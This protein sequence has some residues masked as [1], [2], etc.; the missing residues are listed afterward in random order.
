MNYVRSDS[1]SLVPG[2]AVS[3]LYPGLGILGANVPA[4]GLHGPSPLLNDLV[5]LPADLAV[6]LRLVVTV[7]PV[8]LSYFWMDEDGSIVAMG[9]PG[10]Y[11][12]TVRL[13]ADGVDRGTTTITLN[14][15]SVVTA[16][17]NEA[18]A[19]ADLLGPGRV[20]VGQLLELL[21]T[22]DESAG[23]GPLVLAARRLLRNNL[24]ALRRP[25]N[26]A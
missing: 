26:Q 9:A 1:A 6:Q 19:L 18:A 22:T 7:R 23:A 24:S 10:S 8:G 2:R 17:V 25:P 3:S 12:F 14:F 20:R 11:P 4:T 13:Y 21:S 5:S 16:S 15:G